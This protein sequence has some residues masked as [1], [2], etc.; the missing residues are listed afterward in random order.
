M[1]S[2]RGKTIGIYL[3]RLKHMTG[4]YTISGSATGTGSF[5]RLETA[6]TA[7]ITSNLT[8]NKL[9]LSNQGSQSSCKACGSGYYTDQNVQT[10][11]KYCTPGK[12]QASSATT[13]CGNCPGGQYTNQNVKQSR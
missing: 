5:G 6:G 4:S 10:G 1:L 9:L 12:F 7:K 11:C 8:T 13:S 3:M 2:T